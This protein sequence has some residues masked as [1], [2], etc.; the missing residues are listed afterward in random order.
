MISEVVNAE[1]VDV[2][3]QLMRFAGRRHRLI[4]N[5]IANFSTPGVRPADL[6]VGEFQQRLGR[7]IDERR[8]GGGAVRG[9]LRIEAVEPRP[10][11]SNILVHDGSDRDL[12]RTMQS[13]AENFMTFR[14]AA[15]LM[16]SRF[17][18]INSAIRE[19]V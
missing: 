5:N 11:G 7:A 8:S 19:R 3:E 2:L 12:E 9:P 18:L 13:L 16:R 6:S 10:A 1:G 15:E 14:L 17:D 4:T